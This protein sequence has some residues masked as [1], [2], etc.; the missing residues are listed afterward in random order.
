[1]PQALQSLRFNYV[2]KDY[3]IQ[4]RYG[5]D[6]KAWDESLKRNH[7]LPGCTGFKPIFKNSIK[8]YNM[9]TCIILEGP[10]GCSSKDMKK[11]CEG[12]GYRSALDSFNKDAGR[13]AAL[14]DAVKCAEQAFRKA[15]WESYFNR[16]PTRMVEVSIVK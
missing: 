12:N 16:K 9:T 5:I 8:P 10:V 6:E 4:F 1:M 2:D 14:T 15:A 11:V 7:A 3:F 13:K